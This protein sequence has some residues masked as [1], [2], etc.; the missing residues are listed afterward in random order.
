MINYLDL[1]D[2]EDKRGEMYRRSFNLPDFPYVGFI[3]QTVSKKVPKVS[4]STFYA[5]SDRLFLTLRLPNPGE[6]SVYFY[7]NVRTHLVQ[8]SSFTPRIFKQPIAN[9]FMIYS[10]S[11]SHS[12]NS[13]NTNIVLF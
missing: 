12:D 5:V 3:V 1:H 2:H 7:L 4:Q 8:R 9:V 11:Q 10:V 13:S 6:C